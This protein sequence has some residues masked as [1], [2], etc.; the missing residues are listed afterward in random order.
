MQH[1]TAL[2][3]SWSGPLTPGAGGARDC[4]G[5]GGG[6]HR[7]SAPCC[8]DVAGLLRRSTLLLRYGHRRCA[9]ALPRTSRALLPVPQPPN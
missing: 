2:G 4:D 7:E 1:A 9:D 5:G 3:W 8:R 6:G